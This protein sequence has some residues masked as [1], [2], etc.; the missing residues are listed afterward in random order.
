[1]NKLLLVVFLLMSNSV[2]ASDAAMH[3][4]LVN[5]S[6]S[7]CIT[8]GF[9]GGHTLMLKNIRLSFPVVG[10][11]LLEGST[12]SPVMHS[13]LD[14]DESIVSFSEDKVVFVIGAPK[15]MDKK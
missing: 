13:M 7:A 11:P 15:K 2:Q 14:H 6:R 12:C 8:V 4:K 10:L 9:L 3:E 1:M 5:E